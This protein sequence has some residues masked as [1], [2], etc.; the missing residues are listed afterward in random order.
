M[1]LVCD[2]QE[3]LRSTIY[4]FPHVVHTTRHMLDVARILEIPVIVTEQYPKGLGKTLAEL[5]ISRA[6][7]FEKGQFSMMTEEVKKAVEETKRTQIILVGIETHVCILQTALD[8]I[9]DG[10]DVFLIT[11]GISSSRALDRSAALARLQKEGAVITTSGS[12]VLEMIKTK[13]HE[14]FSELMQLLK[15]FKFDGDLISSL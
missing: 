14:R 7:V 13:D 12:V 1:L 15:H 2:L 9:E 5:D 6:Q 10:K 8:L 4:K 11:D 3:K